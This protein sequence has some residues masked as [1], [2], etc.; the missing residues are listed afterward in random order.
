MYGALWI[1]N[2]GETPSELWT[3]CLIK[4]GKKQIKKG[5]DLCLKHNGHY[6]PSL[7]EF[8][9]LCQTE[10]H[11]KMF[12]IQPCPVVDKKIIRAELN[13]MRKILRAS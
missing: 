4:L 6:P 9:K 13:A 8:L 2:Y 11:Q 7:S 10:K 12:K 3:K 1:K 5:L